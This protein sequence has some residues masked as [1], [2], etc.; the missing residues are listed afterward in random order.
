MEHNIVT[1]LHFLIH[2]HLSVKV[3]LN[4]RNT[5]KISCG[6]IKIFWHHYKCFGGYGLRVILHSAYWLLCRINDC[7]KRFLWQPMTCPNFTNT[8]F[9]YSYNFLSIVILHKTIAE[10]YNAYDYLNTNIWIF[11]RILVLYRELN[12][13]EKI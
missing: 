4:I 5:K 2:S 6:D 12:I 1:V 7:G 11:L 3:S 13:K 10:Y 8:I 9:Y